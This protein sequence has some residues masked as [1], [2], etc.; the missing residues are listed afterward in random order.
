MVSRL[1]ES[2]DE[3]QY[4]TTAIS[5]QYF[6]ISVDVQNRAPDQLVNDA[7]LIIA[8]HLVIKG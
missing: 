2:D 4:R 3:D 7:A 5:L 6:G 8:D 1:W